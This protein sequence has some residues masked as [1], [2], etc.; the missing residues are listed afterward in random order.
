[1]AISSLHAMPDNP[2]NFRAPPPSP[3]ASGRRS[4]AANRF[5][6]G[7]ILLKHPQESFSNHYIPQTVIQ[8]RGFWIPWQELGIFN[9]LI[10]LN[11]CLVIV[12]VELKI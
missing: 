3:I 8:F 5:S 9:W 1:M 11:C 12:L 6:L 10:I 4:F 7:K 2:I